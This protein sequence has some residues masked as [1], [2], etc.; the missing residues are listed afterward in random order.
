MTIGRWRRIAAVLMMLVGAAIMLRGACYALG[1]DE[2]WRPLL[3]SVVLGGLIFAL[4]IA[5]WRYWR[6]Q[7]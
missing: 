7:R 3:V 5:R 4:G 6:E 1:R 2:G